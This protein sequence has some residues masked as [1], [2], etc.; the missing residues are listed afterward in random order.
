MLFGKPVVVL[1]Q[2]A[3]CLLVCAWPASAAEWWQGSFVQDG[4]FP[5]CKGNDTQVSY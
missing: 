1:R 2:G 5:S 3:V 4:S